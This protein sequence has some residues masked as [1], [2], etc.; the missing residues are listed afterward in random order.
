MK[1]AACEESRGEL[2][3][4]QSRSLGAQG[5]G[6]GLLLEIHADLVDVGSRGTGGHLHHMVEE[7]GAFMHAKDE[8]WS[9][10]G[11]QGLGRLEA[12]HTN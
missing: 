10:Q 12:K 4:L 1:E 5:L 7:L 8:A 6:G 3:E 11:T 9:H 2:H